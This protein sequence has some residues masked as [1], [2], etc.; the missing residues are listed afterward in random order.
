MATCCRKALRGFPA[1]SCV[2]FLVSVL[3]AGHVLAGPAIERLDPAMAT[4][5]AESGLVWYDVLGL[6][7]EGQGWSDVADPFARLPARA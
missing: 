6:G 2:F 7:L 3:A 1:E 5:D 4:A